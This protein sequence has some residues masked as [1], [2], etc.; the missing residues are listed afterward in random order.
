MAQISQTATWLE[1]GA[2]LCPAFPS[3]VTIW[4]AMSGMARYVLGYSV[5]TRYNHTA[6]WIRSWQCMAFCAM[7][8]MPR[9]GKALP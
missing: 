9:R 1:F 2:S 6:R 3:D 7:V 4:A 8:A 5:P